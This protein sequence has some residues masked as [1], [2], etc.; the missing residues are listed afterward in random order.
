MRQHCLHLSLYTITCWMTKGEKSQKLPCC[1]WKYCILTAQRKLDRK[2]RFPL[3]TCAA[4]PLFMALKNDTVTSGSCAPVRCTLLRVGWSRKS[5]EGSVDATVL[6]DT[7]SSFGFFF[8]FVKFCPRGMPEMKMHKML[9][10]PRFPIPCLFGGP[11]ERIDY[12]FLIESLL[13][14]FGLLRYF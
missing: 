4:L 1:F 3:M 10:C 8:I 12:F 2:L 13:L 5:R 14:R 11:N 6:N 7:S 9:Q